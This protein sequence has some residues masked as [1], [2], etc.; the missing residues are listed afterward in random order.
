[1]GLRFGEE[2]DGTGRHP[3]QAKRDIAEKWMK[4]DL[5]LERA[6]DDQIDLVIGQRAQNSG[7]WFALLVMN[8][9]FLRQRQLSEN[10]VKF[11]GRFFGPIAH[12]NDVKIAAK[13]IKHAFRLG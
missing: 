12:V 1:F 8:R 3:H 5:L 13:A 10:V 2:H 11:S 7:G 9:G 6:D 4:D